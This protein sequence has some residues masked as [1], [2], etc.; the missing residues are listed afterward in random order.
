MVVHLADIDFAAAARHNRHHICSIPTGSSMPTTAASSRQNFFHDLLDRVGS[1]FGTA[2][3]DD[4]VD[5]A[6]DHHHAVAENDALIARIKPIGSVDLVF[7][8]AFFA[9]L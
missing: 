1:R 4:F 8:R 6:V 3:I 7:A 2:S 5:P 9:Y